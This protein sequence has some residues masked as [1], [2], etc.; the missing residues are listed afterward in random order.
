M[1]EIILV[2]ATGA[3]IAPFALS[4]MIW[5]IV[6]M[7]EHDCKDRDAEME[8]RMAEYFNKLD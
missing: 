1:L 5:G 6:K 4:A 7:A 8:R 2:I 3:I